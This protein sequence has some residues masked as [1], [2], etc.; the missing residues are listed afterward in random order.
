M[1]ADNKFL[2]LYKKRMV[3][4]M[5][6]I[7]PNWDK[8]KV[9]QIVLDMI[10]KNVKNPKVDLDNNFT[11]EHKETTLLS[12]FDWALTREPIIA[13]N[14]TFYKNQNEALNPIT[15]MLDDMASNRKAYKKEMFKVGETI[16]FGSPEYKDLDRLQNNEKINMNSYYGGSGAP[17]SAFFSKWSGPA[18]TL[19]AQSV[20]STAE[21]MFESFLAGN[22]IY[23]NLTELIEWCETVLKNDKDLELDDFIEL[24]SKNDLFDLLNSKILQPEEND[25]EILNEYI[26]SLDD[27]Q[28]TILYY[29]NNMIKFI[30]THEYIKDIFIEI[31]ENV[32]NMEYGSKDSEDWYINLPDDIK[33]KFRLSDV[34]EYNKYV[35]KT[36]FMDPNDPPKEIR[37]SLGLLSDYL[38]K[39]C[40]VRYLSV[41]RIYRLRN[42]I[43]KV[44]TVIDTDSNFLSLD[45]LINYIM[46]EIV[47]SNTF[48]RDREHNEFIAINTITYTI[49]NAIEDMLLYYG[50]CSN[51]PEEERPRFNMKNEFYNSLLIIGKAKKRYISKQVLREGNLLKPNKS[52]IKGFD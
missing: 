41:D 3:K 37:E 14:G 26:N 21:T 17:S 11:G 22:Y 31:F 42:F 8:D 49:T 32:E 51:I 29:K 1:R 28:V 40:Y 25:E 7:N 33:D 27:R 39:Y 20:I 47:G 48:G 13:G 44:V 23:L 50:E 5:C 24:A 35:D 2:Q 43:R 38:M 46:D 10:K 18:T 30:D 6:R 15:K 36:Y 4:V 34:K 19:T 16:G 52:D 9:E 45:T 12:V